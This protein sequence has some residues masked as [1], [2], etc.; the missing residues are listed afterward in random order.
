MSQQMTFA[1]LRLH[2]CST[3]VPMVP[4]PKMNT[5]SSPSTRARFV[6]CS[7]IASGSIS[8]ASLHG[9]F[10][11]ILYTSSAGAVKYSRQPPSALLP[12]TATVSQTFSRP[13]VHW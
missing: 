7:P 5:V 13:C 2:A 8:A 9:M 1:P 3:I 10:G 12:R 11:S 4:V 6:E